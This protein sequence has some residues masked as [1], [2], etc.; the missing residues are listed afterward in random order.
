MRRLDVPLAHLGAI[1]RGLRD[2]ALLIGLNTD[3]E[4]GRAWVI[5]DDSSDNPARRVTEIVDEIVARSGE[6]RVEAL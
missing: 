5:V 4:N 6:A 3:A 1:Q 2:A